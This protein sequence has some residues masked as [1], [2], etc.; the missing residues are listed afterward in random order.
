[1]LRSL[2]VISFLT[3]AITS[4]AQPGKKPSQK[5]N[6]P[7]QAEI[8]KIMEAAMKD[9]SPEEKQQMKEA[10]QVADQM[11]QKGMTGNIAGSVPKIPKKQNP[12]LSKVPVLSSQ[13]QYNA[14][15]ADLLKEC[16]KHIEPKVVA[17]VDQL[18][19]KNGNN[20]KA[21][22]NIGPV[23]FL[24]KSVTA[25]VYAAIKTA[26]NKP[27][28]VL[29]HDNLAV[30]LHQAGYPQKALPILKFLLPNNN[31]PVV[32]NNLGQAYLSLGD[33]ANARKSFM[34]CL[35]KDADHCE[36][37][38]GMG[39]LLTEEGKIGEATP[40]IIRSLKNGY[41]E[42]A[43]ALSKKNKIKLKFSDIKPK[44][45]EYFNPQKYKPVPPS[46]TMETV[47]TTEELRKDLESKMRIWVQKKEKVNKEQNDKI[48]KESLI[49]IADRSRGYLS[50]KPFAKKAQLM[51]NLLSEEYYEFVAA[52]YKNKYLLQQKEYNEQMEKALKNM[53]G[54]G[55]KYDNEFEECKKKIE[56]LNTYLQL[57]AKNHEAYQR[58]TL[59]HVYDWVN[60]SLFWWYFLGNEDAYSIQFS[61]HVSDFFEALHGYDQMQILHP[62]PL[63]IATTCKN[64]KE[65]EKITTVEDSLDMNC[66]VNVKI[67]FGIG[68]TKF[69][70]KGLEIEGG[71]ILVFG[72]EEDYKTGEFSFSFG[73]GVEENI[74]FFSAATKGQMFFKFDKDFSPI[75]CGMKFEAGGEANVL[76]YNVEEKT[77][78]IIGMT[79]G[80]HVNAVDMGKETTI[81]EMDPTK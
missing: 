55:R 25:A 74:P 31:Y 8:N 66:P 62:T 34:A 7:T 61:N 70:C 72:Y 9:M 22:I 35:Q 43:D 17:E 49:Q 24:H 19:L 71:E 20:D 16:K 12:L 53:Y 76:V 79:S 77:V 26:M 78:A 47:E 3:L 57:T 41:T 60:Q 50:N 80:I 36:A 75:D 51:V 32:L 11:K 21:L 29:M 45:P 10:M 37:N 44:V 2:L 6:P 56:I 68:S 58:A 39:L 15:L 52:D 46:Y 81:F 48:E 63:W 64:V 73:L 33:T 38:C 13:Q 5:N 27:G 23:L 30:I 1:M 42:T 18:I 65:P 54:G 69:N 67:P 59:P 40:Y 28:N 14:Y 4:F